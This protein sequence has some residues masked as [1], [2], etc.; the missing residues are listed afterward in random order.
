MSRTIAVPQYELH[1]E[2]QIDPGRTALVVVDMQNDFVSEGGTV[3]A[4]LS[5]R[6]G[7]SMLVRAAG[8]GRSSTRSPRRQAR[9]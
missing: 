5:G 9:L 4:I 1:A 6:S 2:V 7:P 8:A 3:T